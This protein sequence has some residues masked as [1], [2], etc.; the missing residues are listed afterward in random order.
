MEHSYFHKLSRVLWGAIVVLIVV[1]ATYV[2]FGRL[3]MSSV[4]QYEAQ[5]LEEL[6]ERLPFTLEAERVAGEWHFFSPE[7]ILTGLKVT[8]PGS[9]EPPIELN[10]GRITLDVLSSLQTRSLQVSRLLLDALSLK[11]KLSDEGKFTIVGM[12]E[13]RRKMGDWLER[14]LLNIESV[15]LTNNKLALS[16]PNNQLRQLQLDLALR[17]NGSNRLLEAKIFSQTTGTIIS[18]VAEGVGNPMNRDTFVGELYLNIDMSDLGAFQQLLNRRSTVDVQGGLQAELWLG[19]DRGAPTVA[20]KMEGQDLSFSG[21]DQ[22]WQLPAKRVSLEASLVERKDHWTVFVSDFK[23]YKDDIELHLPRLQLDSWGDS[24]RLRAEKVALAPLNAL[25]VDLSLTPDAIADV[26][27]VLDTR[28]ELSAVQLDV[29]DVSAPLDDWELTAN[30][31]HLA[32]DSWRGAPGVTSAKGYVELAADGGYVVL[33]SQSFSMG[34]PTVYKKPLYYEDFFGTINIDW[35]ADALNLS[36]GR[37]SLSGEEGT[38]YVLFGLNIPLA[39]SNVGLEMDLLVGLRDFEPKYRTKYLPF[40]LSDALLGWLKPSIGEGRIEQ[41]AFIWRGSLL[42]RKPTLKTIQLFFNIADTQLNYHPDWPPVSEVN[43]IV[44]ID[45]TNVSVWSESGKLFNSRIQHLSAETWIDENNAM[46]LSV[47]GSL[48]GGAEDGL[49]VVNNSPITELVGPVFKSWQA[50]GQLHTELDLQMGLSGTPPPPGINVTTLWQGVDLQVNPGNLSIS[51]IEGVFSYSSEAGFSS[52][53]LTGELWGKV[54]GAEVSQGQQPSAVEVALSTAIEMADVQQ[55]LDMDILALAKGETKADILIEVAPE[56][57]ATLLV[58]SDLVGVDLD[59]PQPWGKSSTQAAP[60]HVKYPLSGD[61]SLLEMNLRSNLQFDLQLNQGQFTGA[62]LSFHKSPG[63]VDAG[64]LRIDGHTPLLDVAQ[65]QDF[66][67]RYIE[68]DFLVS[69]EQGGGLSVEIDVLGV[70]TLILMEQDIRDVVFSLESLSGTWNIAAETDW[71]AGNLRLAGDGEMSTL[72]IQSLD[73]AALDQLSST[74]T[75]SGESLKIPGMSVSIKGLHTGGTTLGELDFELKNEGD[76]LVA[77][78]IVGN[79]AGL[80]MAANAPASLRWLQGEGVSK[81]SFNAQLEFADF[82]ATLEQ[83]G[84][85]R[86]LETESGQ[87]DVALEWPG[88]P[89]EFSL[90]DAQGS[91][92]ISLGEGR[93]LNAPEGA[94]GTLRVLNILNLAEIIGRLSLTHMFKSG[95]PFHGV[96]GEVFLQDGS[97]DVANIDVEGSTGGFQFSGVADV[98]SESLDGNLVITLPVANNLPWIVALTAGLPVAAGVFVVSKVFEKQVNRLTSGVYRVSGSWDDPQV[99]FE[100]IFDDSSAASLKSEIRAVSVQLTD[101]NTP[102]EVELPGDANSPEGSFSEGK[103]TETTVTD[104][105]KPQSQL[106]SQ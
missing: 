61:S 85:Q 106:S 105:N 97:I 75:E 32:V 86:I 25:L 34:F 29:A 103:S 84:Y 43:G 58:S 98:L 37:L 54:L 77:Q 57:G 55:W 71:L 38:A 95:I 100:R 3:L 8:I 53:G 81:T 93:F 17:R 1:L 9:S 28:G 36:S 88:A 87:F 44:L 31:Q 45:D 60:M 104:P 89:Q 80:K 66:L 63:K 18:A 6:N 16:L 94:S 27:E 68:D 64:V 62:A 5:I 74:G 20:L 67:T 33:D 52:Q 101:P 40:I 92:V 47:S 46:L 15:D 96:E 65:W 42:P 99:T 91:L 79:I 14:L 90:A 21:E 10:Q 48:H 22:S 69:L 26:F 39:E 50:K 24:F 82:G 51:N 12:G 72:E 70:D 7:V 30:F 83:L 73:L 35:D 56:E 13:S 59:L 23:F 19:W 76:T 2:S 11:G 4:K 41:G 78:N 49:K 102:V